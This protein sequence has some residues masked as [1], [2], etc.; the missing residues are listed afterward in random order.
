M[1]QSL[2]PPEVG[3]KENEKK[4]HRKVTVMSAVSTTELKLSLMML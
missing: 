2:I 3:K 1:V 4:S